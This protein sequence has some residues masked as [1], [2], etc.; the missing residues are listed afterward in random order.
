MPSFHIAKIHTC[1]QHPTK[2]QELPVLDKTT[3]L[4][5]DHVSLSELASFLRVNQHSMLSISM[6]IT[7]ISVQE[8]NDHGFLYMVYTSQET[9]G[10]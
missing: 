6:P 10:F 9:F 1:D 2:I 8:N 7:N 5:P 3:F 4:I